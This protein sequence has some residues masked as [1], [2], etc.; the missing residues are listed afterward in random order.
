MFNRL[1]NIV[2]WNPHGDKA[3][4]EIPDALGYVYHSLHGSLCVCTN[5]LDLALSLARVN[6]PLPDGANYFFLWQCR[7]FMGW[8]N[9]LGHRC[10]EGWKYLSTAHKRWD[11]MAP[12]FGSELEYKTS[13]VAYYLALNIHELAVEI[14]LGG[15][16]EL[17]TRHAKHFSVPLTFIAEGR[18]INE[19]AISLLIDDPE[20]LTQLWTCV[21]VTREDMEHSWDDWIRLSEAWFFQ[22]PEFSFHG[23]IYHQ[24][25]FEKLQP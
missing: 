22:D 6:I 21:D 17:K 13:L 9:S 16:D 20:S 11:W 19:R 23:Q 5:Q 1:R 15:Q 4:V 3:W 7:E 18:D 12:I 24:H 10:T 2:G 8:S 25:L 14:S